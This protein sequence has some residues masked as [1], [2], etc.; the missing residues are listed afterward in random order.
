MREGK[1]KDPDLVVEDRDQEET[2]GRDP[3]KGEQDLAI[4][5]EDPK[6]ET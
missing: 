5:T 6:K 1:I 2:G 4:V 3:E